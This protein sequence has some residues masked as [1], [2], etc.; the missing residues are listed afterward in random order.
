M[1]VNSKFRTLFLA[2]KVSGFFTMLFF[3]S[4]IFSYSDESLLF[5]VLLLTSSLAITVFKLTNIY[6]IAISEKGITKIY[7]LSNKKEFIE[8]SEIENVSLNRVDGGSTDAGLISEGY[9]ESI[10][11]LKNKKK[12]VVSPDYFENYRELVVAMSENFT[13]YKEK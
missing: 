13:N 2:R 10:I 12:T 8:F 6:K 9:Y 4:V 1:T 11:N 5:L 3:C 7:F